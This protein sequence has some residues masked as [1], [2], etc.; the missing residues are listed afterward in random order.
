VNEDV[1]AARPARLRAVMR[2]A[3]VPAILTSDPIN[4]DLITDD[5]SS[6]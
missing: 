5:G 2:A 4:I 3:G 1:C 6:V